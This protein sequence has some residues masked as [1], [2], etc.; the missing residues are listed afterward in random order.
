VRDGNEL[1]LLGTK[2]K[3]LQVAD[4]SNRSGWIPESDVLRLP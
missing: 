1:T 3:W 2:D 4:V